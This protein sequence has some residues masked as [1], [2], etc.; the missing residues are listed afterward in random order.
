MAFFEKPSKKNV[1]KTA[2]KPLEAQS[3]S[4]PKYLKPKILLLDLSEDVSSALTDSGFNVSI[5]TLG[6]PY[7]VPRRS[8]YLPLIGS[9]EIPPHTE[10]DIVIV[11][12]KYQ[13]IDDG[14][15]G[16]KVRPDGELDL[17]GKCDKGFLDPRV[18]TALSLR[19]S[20]DRIQESGG[21]FIVFADEKTGIE[22]LTAR[23]EFDSLRDSTQFPY[24]VWGILSDLLY[25]TVESDSGTDVKVLGNSPFGRL[26][27]RHLEGVSF[28]CRLI[29]PRFNTRVNWEPLVVN[30]YDDTVA[31]YCHS[32]EFGSIVVLPQI[33]NKAAFLSELLT[34]VLPEVSP[35]LFP[36][37]ERSKWTHWPDYELSRVADLLN[38]QCPFSRR[39]SIGG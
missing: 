28:A 8:S 12:L 9:G 35:H 20:F 37:I 5:G 13:Y 15:L 36:H 4:P 14:P 24:D 23:I 2:E 1:T 18:R 29:A 26:L 27:T 38:Q 3:S 16:E 32:K 39:A 17:W 10:Q 22:L 30:R 11:D 33:H 34:N 25:I 7:K 21:V 6:R 19:A 31:L